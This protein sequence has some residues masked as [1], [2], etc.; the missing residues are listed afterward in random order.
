MKRMF[1]KTLSVLLAVT[2][3]FGTIAFG[4]AEVDWSE[5]VVESY[6]ADDVAYELLGEAKVLADNSI[7]LTELKFWASGGVWFKEKLYAKDGIQVSF[8]Y[9]IGGGRDHYFGGADG[10]VLAFANNTYNLG[11]QGEYLGFV[12]DNA[13]GVEFD[14]YYQNTNDPGYKHIAIL[15]DDVKQ[16]LANVEDDRVDDSLWH[17]VVVAISGKNITVVLDKKEVLSYDNV[18]FLADELYVGF[19]AATG[20]GYNQHII[21][22]VVVKNSEGDFPMDVSFE[23]YYQ[24][25]NPEVP[26]FSITP[27]ALDG[28]WGA[29][30]KVSEGTYESNIG[31][32][33]YEDYFQIER[34]LAIDETGEKSNTIIIKSEGFRNHIIPAEVLESIQANEIFYNLYAKNAYMQIDRNDGNPYISSVYARNDDALEYTD[35]RA[36]EISCDKKCTQNI[37]VSVDGLSDGEQVE[38]VYI[39]QSE[40]ESFESN[41]GVF[42]NINLSEKLEQ[43]KAVYVYAVT[44]KGRQTDLEEIKIKV[45]ANDQFGDG[46]NNMLTMDLLGND[47][48]S[49]GLD[50]NVPFLK[51]SKISLDALKTP[52][53]ISRDG[54]VWRISLGVDIF[55]G[56]K[57][58]SDEKGEMKWKS[59]KEQVDDQFTWLG[60]PKEDEPKSFKEAINKF[61]DVKKSFGDKKK[62]EEYIKANKKSDLDFDFG[63]LGYIEGTFDG[64]QWITTAW[65]GGVL[66][67]FKIEKSS[68]ISILGFPCYWSIGGGADGSAKFEGTRQVASEDVPVEMTF[69][70]SIEPFITGKFGAG[71]DK[72]VYAGITGKGS[73]PAQFITAD[74][75]LKIDLSAAFGWEAGIWILKADGTI[76]SDSTTIVEKYFGSS[77]SLVKNSSAD[78]RLES[79]ENNEV[80][81]SVLPRDYSQTTSEWLYGESSASTYSLRTVVQQGAQFTDLQKSVF[82]DSK[83]QAV[84]VGNDTFAVWIEDDSSRDTY[85]RMRLVYSVRDGDTGLWSEPEPVWDTGVN[86]GYPSIATDGE[87]VYITWQKVNKIVKESD[88]SDATVFYD[89]GE[90]CFAEYNIYKNRVSSTRIIT[91]NNYYDYSPIVI[92]NNGDPVIFWTS[93]EGNNMS[94]MDGC[95]LNRY[96]E[97]TDSTLIEKISSPI[98]ISATVI[99]GKE[100][101]SYC[102]DTDGDFSTTEDITVRT[103]FDGSITT[104]DKGENRLA[105]KDAKY[106]ILDGENVL[107]MQDG[108]NI[109]YED[110][111]ETVNVFDVDRNIDG[112][113]NVVEVVNGTQILW[114]E[115]EENG[116]SNIYS[117]VY[118]EGEWSDPVKVSE[119]EKYLTGLVVVCAN[120]KII[121]LCNRTEIDYNEETQQFEKGLTDLSFMSM[122]D[123]GDVEIELFSYKEK[124]FIENG[125]N[126]FNLNVK[127]NGTTNINEI[128]FVIEDTLGN[129]TTLQKA[130]NLISGDSQIV[131][132]SYIPADNY[133]ATTLTVTAN[134]ENDVDEENNTTS[135]RVGSSDMAVELGEIVEGDDCFDITAFVS[136]VS[137]INAKN[138]KLSVMAD[139]ADGDVLDTVDFGNI[140]GSTITD[141]HISI[142]KD[143]VRFSES[144]TGVVYINL[145][146]DDELNNCNNSLC[147]P[148]ILE[149]KKDCGHP[150]TENREKVYPTRTEEG[151][152]AGEYCLAC[153]SFISGGE[154]IPMLDADTYVTNFVAEGVATRKTF[155]T[156]ERIVAPDNPVKDGYRF[157]GWTPEVPDIMPA[158][159][160][161]FIAVFEEINTD[162]PTEPTTK[163]AEPTTEPTEPTTEPTEPTTEPTEPTTKPVVTVPALAVEICNPS[164]TEINYGDSIIL[165]ADTKNLPE[166]AYIEW[167]AD[168]GNFKIVS[169]SADGSGC[170]VTPD[171]TGDTTFTATVYDA[172][173]KEICSDTQTMTAKAGFFQ[174]LI[175]FF[176]KLFGLTKVIPEAFKGIL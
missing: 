21:K 40:K 41:N 141:T 133:A 155:K 116:C 107:F 25:K 163:P 30:K 3:V 19:A 115:T 147:V 66:A 103:Y 154:T 6:A 54:D 9:W 167:S 92:V 149:N 150:V 50:I 95:K 105:I 80:K 87:N 144:G 172:D 81:V 55:S 53:G 164:Q 113:F 67:N 7:E 99:D 16:H 71:I 117:C 59:F 10:L 60:D 38:K 132:I 11:E 24:G 127:N 65:E 48:Q 108:I 142:K 69:L 43:E 28:G 15:K 85:N 62:V 57:D 68:P 110:N 168:N 97:G 61:N 56:E 34:S 166:G 98:T 42:T 130:V 175:A 49:I 125:S 123:F 72:L 64:A 36:L 139:S 135:F 143:A 161:T 170:T 126:S 4:I 169:Y 32:V 8:S 153:N 100:F 159:D 20:N 118:S 122:S 52:I 26:S 73:V 104:F 88:C 23:K 165:H 44:S 138:V 94:A 140:V 137:L 29:K 86:D 90:I 27:Q 112:K 121:G 145:T 119:N 174:K 131:E 17:D 176:K 22:D 12:H 31:S 37:I 58:L 109:F 124:S 171:A 84:Q 173:G 111:G 129:T 39:I 102:T 76:W 101:V 47:G 14:S 162:I 151:Y 74:K 114:T 51:D 91:N 2:M 77:K 120:G 82:E 93:S 79:A 148:L 75:Y 158:E 46:L 78:Y 152:E 157:V 128:E 160:L 33:E 96:C 70:F 45:G 106:G 89:N 146:A 136:N 13:L 134:I 63:V 5:F 35:V 18:D 156:G 1:K 83:I